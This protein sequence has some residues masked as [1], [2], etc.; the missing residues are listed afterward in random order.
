VTQANEAHSKNPCQDN[1][2]P[3]M[4]YQFVAEGP[5]PN[6]QNYKYSLTLQPEWCG[7]L[8]YCIRAFPF[9]TLL[10]NAHEMGRMKWI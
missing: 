6:S 2:M 7:G 3:V 5:L 4:T 9:H 1:A 10:A 8:V